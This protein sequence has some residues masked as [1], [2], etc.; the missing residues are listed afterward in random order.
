MSIKFTKCDV[1]IESQF[2]RAFYHYLINLIHESNKKRYLILKSNVKM[3]IWEVVILTTIIYIHGSN[4]F[5]LLYD[6]EDEN[7]VQYNNCI[8]STKESEISYCQRNN[9]SS[10][11]K[12]QEQNNCSHEGKKWLFITLLEHNI[13][14][15]EVL[16]W[17]ST[18]EMADNYASVYYNNSTYTNTSFLC[19]C[20][21]PSTFGK[22]CEYRLTHNSPTF[23]ES[24]I[25]QF[26]TKEKHLLYLQNIVSG[27][28]YYRIPCE[29]GLLGLEWRQICDGNQECIDGYDEENCDLLEF[30]ECEDNQ[31]R[32]MNGMCIDEEFWLDG[33]IRRQLFS[34]SLPKKTNHFTVFSH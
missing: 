28:K 4:G 25:F 31:Y 1:S 17:S 8:Y 10:E 15:S 30:N 13:T 26:T 2:Y 33:K 24:T 27:T 34:F 6:T 32:C 21:M 16:K 29:S 11:F 14:P 12:R 19:N 7:S 22:Y 5:V 9:L 18:I 20:T 3:L 23:E